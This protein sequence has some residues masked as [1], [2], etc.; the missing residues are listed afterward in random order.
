MNNRNIRLAL[1]MRFMRALPLVR[2][3]RVF[4]RVISRN[5]AQHVRQSRRRAISIAFTVAIYAGE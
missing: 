4:L 2:A 1:L 5:T 3:S